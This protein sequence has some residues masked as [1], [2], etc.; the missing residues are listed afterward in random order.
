MSLIHARRPAHKFVPN[1]THVLLVR[2]PWVSGTPLP[3]CAGDHA[4]I[5]RTAC[6]LF[7]SLLCCWLLA[8]CCA[9]CVLQCEAASV[10]FFS[11]CWLSFL[12]RRCLKSQGVERRWL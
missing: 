7:A 10:A 1:T 4:Y 5:W 2:L 9:A 3:A 11:C 12:G 6:M 8:V